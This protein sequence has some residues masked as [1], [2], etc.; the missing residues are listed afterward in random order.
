[1]IAGGGIAAVEAVLALR[2]LA[3]E[4][5]SLTMISP[6]EHLLVRPLSVA[7][8]FEGPQVR[9]YPL[10]RICS[11]MEAELVH[12]AL[13]LVDDRVGCVFTK[14]DRRLSYDALV[15]AV[16]APR[17]PV[18]EHACTFTGE[19]HAEEMRGLLQDV[20]LGHKRRIAFVAPARAGWTLPLYELV[21][22]TA[23]RAH[24]IGVAPQLTLVTAEAE[25]LEAFRGPASQAVSGLLRH[26]GVK[27]IT[28]VAASSYDGSLLTSRDRR[29]T[30]VADAVVALPAQY[31]P[32]M[33]GLRSDIHNFLPVDGLGRVEGRTAV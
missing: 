16:G 11:D 21:L 14:R 28:G 4:R 23:H 13:R 25:P 17:R 24:S 32:I 26:A 12:D 31:G 6:D 19:E 3:G 29:E 27:V 33:H 15:I 5:V 22:Q 18:L 9:R 8:P 30:L 1:V 10:D 2:T 7:E 20:E